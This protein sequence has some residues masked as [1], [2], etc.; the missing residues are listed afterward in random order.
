MAEQKKL[1]NIR[2]IA[3]QKS[4]MFRKNNLNNTNLE[5]KRKQDLARQNLQLDN[6]LESVRS[7]PEP[8]KKKIIKKLTKSDTESSDSRFSSKSSLSINPKAEAIMKKTS[9][10][11]KKEMLQKNSD[12][13]TDDISGSAKMRFDKN[14]QKLLDIHD[15]ELDDMSKESI[16]VG[17]SNKDKKKKD[18]KKRTND[19]IDFNISVGSINKGNKPSMNI[20]KK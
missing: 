11:A 6:I 19:L 4:E 5:D 20:G 18:D 10:K 3:H 14:I 12:N 9:E 17:S 7:N 8:I 1:E 13:T 2:K 15:P 16:S